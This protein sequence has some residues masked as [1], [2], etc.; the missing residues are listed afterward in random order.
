[1]TEGCNSCSKRSSAFFSSSPPRTTDVVVPSP[2]SASTVFATSTI[3]FAAGLSMSISFRI[4]APSFVITTSPRESTSILSIP[5]GPNVVRTAAATAF[6]AFIFAVCASL[7]L[8]LSPPSR[9]T[10]IGTPPNC[11]AILFILTS[12]F[13]T[14]DYKLIYTNLY[15]TFKSM[16]INL[17][18]TVNIVE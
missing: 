16:H 18:G 17:F 5:F 9:N 4:V 1:M 7:P 12:L 11:P 6:A 8:A 15:V 13:Y 3:I 14:L 2:A 10:N